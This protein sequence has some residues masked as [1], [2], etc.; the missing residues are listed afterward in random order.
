MCVP[1][2]PQNKLLAPA[3]SSS[4][5]SQTLCCC[6]CY[7]N[8]HGYQEPIDQTWETQR[9]LG[10]QLTPSVACL[11]SVHLNDPPSEDS[12]KPHHCQHLPL[13]PGDPTLHPPAPQLL[14][15]PGYSVPPFTVCTCDWMGA[16]GP[17]ETPCPPRFWDMLPFYEQ[18]G[19]D[20]I[21]F[22]KLED[23]NYFSSVVS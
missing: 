17:A 3:P 2:G 21:Y 22:F 5:L 8:E 12:R 10:V 11:C 4:P 7:N 20:S 6:R 16:P 18:S 14:L 9:Q 19:V 1:H 13:L 23:R 15:Y